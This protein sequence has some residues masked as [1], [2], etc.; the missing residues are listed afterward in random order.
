MLT[1]LSQESHLNDE[2]YSTEGAP[3]FTLIL[4]H[5]S[6]HVASSVFL[7]LLYL[8]LKRCRVSVE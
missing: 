1:G 7:Q 6:R 4:T 5:P 2:L 3:L 8:E